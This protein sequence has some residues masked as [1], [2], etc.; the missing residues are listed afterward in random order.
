[1]NVGVGYLSL[2]RSG[3][4]LSGGEAQRIQLA[5]ALGGVLTAALYVRMMHGKRPT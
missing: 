2:D 3:N 1:M 4:S 5:T